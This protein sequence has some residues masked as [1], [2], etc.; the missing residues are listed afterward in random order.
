MLLSKCVILDLWILSLKLER[1]SGGVGVGSGGGWMWGGEGGGG[2]G[3]LTLS[4][5]V[6]ACF[7]SLFQ[8]LFDSLFFFCLVQLI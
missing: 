5:F 8:L 3:L 6:W 2:G 7:L 4:S 1:F